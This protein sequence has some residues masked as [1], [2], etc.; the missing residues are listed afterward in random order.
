MLCEHI[1]QLLLFM[2]NTWFQPV[3]CDSHVTSGV[4]R[5]G[6]VLTMSVKIARR[7]DQSR[8][9]ESHWRRARGRE[10]PARMHREGRNHCGREVGW[11]LSL[12]LPDPYARPEEGFQQEPGRI[13][14]QIAE[15]RRADEIQKG[16]EG[17][18]L[19]C[20]DAH[21][22]RRS[23][24]RDRGLTY[25]CVCMCRTAY[26]ISATYANSATC[27]RYIGSQHMCSRFLLQKTTR[28]SC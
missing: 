21:A 1:A 25:V 19:G 17:R 2:V 7:R 6:H 5:R 18:E 16:C 23:E 26:C 4:V 20:P 9:E 28:K 10:H 11:H 27:V 15:R 13:P 3:T 24:A 22:E 8:G 12:P 14:A